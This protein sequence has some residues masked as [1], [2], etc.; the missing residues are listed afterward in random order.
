MDW[1]LVIYIYAGAMANGDSVALAIVPMATKELCVKAA[2]EASAL[3]K[4]S[5]KITRTLCLKSREVKP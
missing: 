3:S 5:A 4:N 1:V 2:E